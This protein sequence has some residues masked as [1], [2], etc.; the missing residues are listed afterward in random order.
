MATKSRGVDSMA[1]QKGAMCL[2]GAM[3]V[4]SVAGVLLQIWKE[5]KHSMP[6]QIKESQA[7]WHREPANENQHQ[8]YH[9][10]MQRGR[11]R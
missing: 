9:D 6:A 3:V 4:A 2:M 1:F 10:V 5:W 7:G 8:M 11:S